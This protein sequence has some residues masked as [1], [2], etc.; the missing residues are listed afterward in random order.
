MQ[1]DNL[2]LTTTA[3]SLAT[4]GAAW[5][6]LVAG[7]IA[8]RRRPDNH[9]GPLMVAVCFALLA[10][11]FRYSHDDLAFTVF[12]LIGELGYALV[13]HVALAYPSG[14][15]TDRLE[16]AFLGVAYFVAVAFP[17]AILLF[18]DG[19]QKLRYFDP[20]P[21]ESLIA[22]GGDDGIVSFL[23][24]AYA[25]D[26][27]RRACA[28]RSSSSSR[29]SSCARRRVRGASLWPLLLAAVVAA[30]RAVLDSVLSFSTAPP[31]FTVDLFWWQVL[32]LTAL[33]L[34]HPV[35]I[36]AR[37]ACPRPRRRARG[38]SRG[39]VTG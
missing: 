34:A 8:W 17:F 9:L 24:D 27:V 33:P 28:R 30:L 3:R 7:L 16:R 23:Q 32:A 20:I 35:G 21:R 13:A 26:R 29:G 19:G 15:V 25:R 14:R 12:F 38:A 36:A 10:R 18:H 6:F 5:S 22:V 31:G 2:P 37:A 11:Q 1:I 4:V 39:D